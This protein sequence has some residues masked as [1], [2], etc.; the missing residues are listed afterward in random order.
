[1]RGKNPVDVQFSVQ[2]QEALERL[3]TQH[4]GAGTSTRYRN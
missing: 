3:E 2:G 4:I 1:M